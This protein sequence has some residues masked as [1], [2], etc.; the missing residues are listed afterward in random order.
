MA[1]PL[2]LAAAQ[3]GVLRRELLAQF[4][5][6]LGDDEQTLIDT[7][8][9]L[10]YFPDQVSRVLR[11]INDDEALAAAAKALAAEYRERAERLTDRAKAKRTAVL[12]AM[13]A[14][15]RR[16][17]ELPEGTVSVRAGAQSVVITDEALIPNDFLIPQPAKINRHEIKAALAAG[18]DVPGAVLSNGAPSLAIRRA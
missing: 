11:S 5:E 14:A 10:S 17:L 9:G 12:R 16:K 3:D 4:P 2:A 8:D 15:D 6:A 18:R 13:E 1:D 7:L